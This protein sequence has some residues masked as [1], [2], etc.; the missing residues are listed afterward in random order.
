M[1]P[2]QP[3]DITPEC[4]TRATELSVDP[5]DYRRWER[6]EKVQSVT[7]AIDREAYEAE[8]AKGAD[9]NPG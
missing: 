7:D 5:T 3:S 1:R 6:G 4:K 2:V 9:H 8:Q